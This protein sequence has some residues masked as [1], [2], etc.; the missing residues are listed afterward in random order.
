MAVVLPSEAIAYK[1][2]DRFTY[3][4]AR[5]FLLSGTT[6]DTINI[7]VDRSGLF[8]IIRYLLPLLWTS[9][10]TVD[11]LTGS[12]DWDATTTTLKSEFGT[13]LGKL[14]NKYGNQR[15]YAV[16]KIK[17][18]VRCEP[19]MSDHFGT[20]AF[21]KLYEHENEE[22]RH[23]GQYFYILHVNLIGTPRNQVKRSV[24]LPSLAFAK[25]S[26]KSASPFPDSGAAAHDTAM[27]DPVKS[28][29]CSS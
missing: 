22:F 19:Q 6:M 14:A 1:D 4:R 11:Q 3:V 23:N 12:G 27:P 15:V 26:Q 24:T 25:L 13:H 29:K 7:T 9:L 10:D 17:L 8:L 16:Q 28:S 21:V 5:V 2:S 18:P 20:K